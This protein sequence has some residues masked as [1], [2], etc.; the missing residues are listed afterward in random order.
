MKRQY[1]LMW[2]VVSMMFGVG[3]M[4]VEADGGPTITQDRPVHFIAPDGS[5]VQLPAASYLIEQSG[6]SGLRLA[7]EGAQAI[8]IQATK[9]AHGES[10]SAPLAM[11][12]VEEGKEDDLHLVLVLAGGQGLEAVG[13]YD[14]SLARGLR[15]L[16]LTPIQ[17]QN[18]LQNALQKKMETKN[19]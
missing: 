13:S 18:A 1:T 6:E 12:V 14:G 8:E 2:L 4:T 9:I 11:A 3:L 17:I 19:K 15:V 7:R 5:D 10:V 16:P